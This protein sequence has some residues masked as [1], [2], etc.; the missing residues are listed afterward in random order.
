MPNR[1]VRDKWDYPSKMERHIPIKP[2]QPI[3]IALATIYP[4]P[5]SLIRAKNRFVK[6][7]CKTFKQTTGT[8]IPQVYVGSIVI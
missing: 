6:N 4:F 2:R 7:D 8:M 1:P 3:G 5:N